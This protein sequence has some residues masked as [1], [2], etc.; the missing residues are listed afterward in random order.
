MNPWAAEKLR[1]L[2]DQAQGSREVPDPVELL[3]AKCLQEAEVRFQ[4]EVQK[5]GQPSSNS[6]FQSAVEAPGSKVQGGG[7]WQAT[8]P[9][10]AP[11]VNVGPMAPGATPVAYPWPYPP[12]LPGQLPS[13]N[14]FFQMEVLVHLQSPNAWVAPE[15]SLGDQT[16]SVELPV[17]GLE[18]TSLAF[19]DWLTTLEPIVSEISPGASQW[20]QLTLKSVSKAYEEWLT[21]DPLLLSARRRQMASHGTQNEPAVAGGA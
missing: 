11:I 12:G 18:A 9:V 20:W 1:E 8:K 16:R 6:S 21:A 5:L 2:H 3:R 4:E 13:T 19:G 7:E 17:L 10:T 14:A 15:E